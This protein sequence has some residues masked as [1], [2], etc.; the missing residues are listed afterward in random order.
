MV[1]FNNK[2]ISYFFIGVL[3]I[4]GLGYVINGGVSKNRIY[5]W[6]SN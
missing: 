3:V 4:L 6:Q 1:E 5:Y 2:N